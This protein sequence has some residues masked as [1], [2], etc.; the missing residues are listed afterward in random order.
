M[1]HLPGP[2]MTSLVIYGPRIWDLTE[3]GGRLR[4]AGFIFRHFV[5]QWNFGFPLRA[6]LETAMWINFVALVYLPRSYLLAG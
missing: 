3:L 2:M 5:N 6:I 4:S 1:E